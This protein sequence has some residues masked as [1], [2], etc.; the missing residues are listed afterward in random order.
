MRKVITMKEDK[1]SSET[2]EGLREILNTTDIDEIHNIV[3][4]LLNEEDDCKEPIQLD[5]PEVVKTYLQLRKNL[6]KAEIVYRYQKKLRGPEA[7]IT[8]ITE[9]LL[10]LA[11]K[12]VTLHEDLY[13]DI[14]QLFISNIILA[15]EVNNV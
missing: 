14:K 11:Q 13:L 7:S 3:K 10:G 8:M 2:K 5:A 4:S 15:K 6:E 9:R 1:I 12:A